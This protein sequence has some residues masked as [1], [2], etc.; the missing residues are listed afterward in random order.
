MAQ[1]KL[2]LDRINTTIIPLLPLA[3]QIRIVEKVDQLM[4][5]CDELE[6]KVKENQ[7]NSE[8]LMDAILREA[9]E[10]K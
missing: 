3:E 10:N 2:A 7:K 4:K 8:L 5:F 9:F 1:P 6:E